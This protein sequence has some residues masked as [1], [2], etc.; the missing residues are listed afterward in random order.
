M[1]PVLPTPPGAVC[2]LA[3]AGV[4]ALAS[5]VLAGCG[6]DA[7][8]S[9]ATATRQAAASTPVAC[10]D[11]PSTTLNVAITNGT[12]V[13]ITVRTEPGWSCD[14]FS[15][16]GTPALLDLLRVPPGRS[17]VKRLERRRDSWFKDSTLLFGLSF[18]AGDEKLQIMPIDGKPTL[19]FWVTFPKLPGL[20]YSLTGGT[21]KPA[22]FTRGEGSLRS[23]LPDGRQLKV[24]WFTAGSSSPWQ[25]VGISFRPA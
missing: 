9:P 14:D 23:S 10:P 3:A 11:M 19:G 13:P 5:L 18:Y 7:A 6:S 22:S 2:G 15:E 20:K 24:T 12:D 25:G 17:P 16:T 21:R 8:T 1:A 4:I